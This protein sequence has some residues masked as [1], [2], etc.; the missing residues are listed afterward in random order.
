MFVVLN[1]SE[2]SQFT[3]G[4]FEF[5]PQSVATMWAKSTTLAAGDKPWFKRIRT[6]VSLNQSL[7]ELLSKP[8]KRKQYLS[9]HIVARADRADSAK[10][11]SYDLVLGVDE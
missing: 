6:K 9:L 8:L 3:T 11:W 1:L 2:T 10:S 4:M 5:V 7:Q